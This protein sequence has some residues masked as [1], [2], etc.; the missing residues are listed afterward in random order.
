MRLS[1]FKLLGR[2]AGLYVDL[3]RSLRWCW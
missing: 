3:M 1:G 2:V